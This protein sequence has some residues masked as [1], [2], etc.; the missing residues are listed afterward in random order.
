MANIPRWENIATISHSEKRGEFSRRCIKST[1]QPFGNTFHIANL[2]GNDPAPSIVAA[3]NKLLAHTGHDLA[4][5]DVI[6]LS[7]AFAA[8][9]LAVLR[10][11]GLADDSLL[12]NPNGGAIAL[13]HPLGASGA[14]LVMTAV[15]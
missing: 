15:H 10:S 11:L 14:R 13:G 7:E 5:M 4:K 6:E 1:G 3:V 8:Q 12:V 9:S 2:D